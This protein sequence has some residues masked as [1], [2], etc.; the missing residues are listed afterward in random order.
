MRISSTVSWDLVVVA[1]VVSVVLWR[2]LRAERQLVADLRGELGEVR[3]ALE[4]PASQPV[5]VAAVPES[6]MAAP[7]DAPPAPTDKAATVRAASA[8]V[9]SE[10]AQ[11]QIALMDDPEFRKARL[12]QVRG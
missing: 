10:S 7:V 3:A 9:L 2:E 6:A 12:T 1:G 11:R 4:A 8:V 5:V